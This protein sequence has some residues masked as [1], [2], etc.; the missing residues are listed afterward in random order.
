M[1][2]QSLKEYDPEWARAFHEGTVA[3]SCP[4]ERM[5]AAVRTP[6]LLTHH[7]RSVD[8]ESGALIGACSDLQ[9]KKARDI[10]ATTGVRFEYTSFGDAAHP[11]HNADPERFAR[12]LTDWADS[13]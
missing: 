6:V 10:L 12:V 5:L 2:R 3:A 8:P 13:L 9:A 1:P 4:H 11:M 7:A